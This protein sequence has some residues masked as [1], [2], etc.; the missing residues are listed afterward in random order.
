MKGVEKMGQ[1]VTGRKVLGGQWK[2]GIKKGVG[3]P[4]SWWKG[5][6]RDCVKDA[7]DVRVGREGR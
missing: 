7:F 2:G 3:E 6:E 4:E 1:W 5:C